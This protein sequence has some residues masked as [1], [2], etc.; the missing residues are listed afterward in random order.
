MKL[1]VVE[2][3]GGSPV[4]PITSS[5]QLEST[6]I[7]SLIG[8]QGFNYDVTILQEE[9]GHTQQSDLF[10]LEKYKLENYEKKITELSVNKYDAVL[11][12]DAE[13]VLRSKDLP[14]SNLIYL[15]SDSKPF[16]SVELEEVIKLPWVKVIGFMPSLKEVKGLKVD[17]LCT[18]VCYY[19]PTEDTL[20][21]V[22]HEG[23]KIIIPLDHRYGDSLNSVLTP[24]VRSCREA[25]PNSQII[26]AFLGYKIHELLSDDPNVTC[27]ECHT[28]GDYIG[29]MVKCDLQVTCNIPYVLDLFPFTAMSFGIP[30]ALITGPTFK[31]NYPYLEDAFTEILGVNSIDMEAQRAS[32]SGY[33]TYIREQARMHDEMQF[34]IQFHTALGA[35][36][37]RDYREQYRTSFAEKMKQVEEFRRKQL[38]KTLTSTNEAND[39]TGNNG[40]Q[41]SERRAEEVQES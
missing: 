37:N 19:D 35:L 41:E 11:V 39:A 13:L 24:T 32:D 26:L 2:K 28:L 38:E 8:Y 12:F 3:V 6:V 18:P 15:C 5:F 40:L 36:I 7:Y 29:E 10:K 23:Y 1:L 31:N 22:K 30:V 4:V 27:I 33:S 34:N 16:L 20:L 25:Y 9:N 17:R 14:I 21:P